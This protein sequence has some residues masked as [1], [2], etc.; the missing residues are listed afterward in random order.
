LTS[1]NA[2]THLADLT[3]TNGVLSDMLPAQSITLFVLPATNSFN[4]KIGIEITSIARSTND[5][6][7]TWT[8]SSAGTNF[9]Q[10]ENGG[11][12][13]Y[14]TNNFQTID[15]PVIV[16]AGATNSYTDVGGATNTPSRF[17]RI[18]YSH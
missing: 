2:I 7:I 17:Y 6:T 5:I 16:S 1:A 12:N 4:L 8:T 15:G 18:L 13:G 10:A 11:A 9:V 3:V 14:N